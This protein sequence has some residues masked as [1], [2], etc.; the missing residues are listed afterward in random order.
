MEHEAE[1]QLVAFQQFDLPVSGR[2]GYA[3]AAGQ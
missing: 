2:I 3:T 1:V